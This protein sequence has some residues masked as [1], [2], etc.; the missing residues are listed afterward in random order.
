[1]RTRFFVLVLSAIVVL[2]ISAYFGVSAQDAIV[3]PASPLPPPS[4]TA[5][6]QPPDPVAQRALDYVA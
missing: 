4:P 2:S 6:A 1:M 3:Q 5:E